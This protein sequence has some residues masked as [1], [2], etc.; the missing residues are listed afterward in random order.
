MASRRSLLLTLYR[1]ICS[2]LVSLIERHHFGGSVGT[3]DGEAE[4][5]EAEADDR[6]VT[7]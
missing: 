1:A 3:V 5:A 2:A 4:G 6:A 7:L